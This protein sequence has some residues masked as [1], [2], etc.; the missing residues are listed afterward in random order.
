MKYLKIKNDGVLDIRLVALMGGTTK[1]NDIYKIGQFGTGLK[2]T[3]AYLFRNSVEFRIFAGVD[4][5]KLELETETIKDELFKIICINGNRTSITTRMGS[6]WEAWMIVRE[7]YSNALDEGGAEYGIVEDCAGSED[8][9]CFY[10]ELTTEFLKVYNDWD[11]YFI[12]GRMPM[13]ETPVYALHPTGGNLKIYKQGILIHEEDQPALFS[14]DIKNA[15]INELREYKGYIQ[16]DLSKIIF[17]VDDT[18]VISYY[19]ENVGEKHPTLGHKYYEANIDLNFWITNGG[20]FTDKWKEVIGD[21]KLIHPKAKSDIIAKQANVDLTHTVE[22]PENFYKALTQKFE[23]IGA[24]RVA[25]KVSE[26]Y[27]I[28]DEELNLKVKSAIAILESCNYF[29]HPELKFIFGEFGCKSTLAQISMD[30]KE[31]LISQRMKDK[32]MFEFCAML[33]EEG[34]HFQTGMEDHTREFQQHFINLY[35]KAML[36]KSEVK[37]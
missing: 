10:I 27:E 12:V 30:K 32:S 36:D 21:A 29:I 24:L 26:F 25:N 18:K 14:Y 13:Y 20:K 1:Q 23:G 6:E 28:Y 9:T 11:K 19:L 17:S 34:E 37:L 16:Y 31:I 22:V 8:T 3:L 35:V 5:V 7:L 33:V 4:E 15:T 2:Y